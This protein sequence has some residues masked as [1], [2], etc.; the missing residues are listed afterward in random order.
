METNTENFKWSIFRENRKLECS[1][2]NGNAYHNLLPESQVSERLLDERGSRTPGIHVFWRQQSR[3]LSHSGCD[4]MHKICT[5]ASQTKSQYGVSGDGHEIIL[6]ADKLLLADRHE[7]RESHIALM[8]LLLVGQP[9]FRE[10]STPK[11]SCV[12][13]NGLN[14]EGDHRK[15]IAQIAQVW[16]NGEMIIE[17]VDMGSVEGVNMIKIHCRKFSKN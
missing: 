6:K 2:L 15:K 13:Q 9:L 11:T 1:T 8:T 14:G 16:V 3:I 7:D 12:T 5:R 17:M 4:S 10:G